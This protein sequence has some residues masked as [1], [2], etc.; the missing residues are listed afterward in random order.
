[1]MTYKFFFT[2]LSCVAIASAG[3]QTSPLEGRWRLESA[4][5][6]LMENGIS[7]LHHTLNEQEINEAAIPTTLIFAGKATAL[8]TDGE[9]LLDYSYE[10][11]IVSFVLTADKPTAYSGWIEN[12]TSL[13]LSSSYED[14]ALNAY[15]IRVIYKK[16]N[17]GQ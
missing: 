3:A 10:N 13:V 2:F 12:E 17:S 4:R 7:Q 15:E 1:M 8:L 11:N 5:I 14:Q 6:N 16:I 9:R